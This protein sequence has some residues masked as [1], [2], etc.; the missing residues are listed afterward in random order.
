[1]CVPN[2]ESVLKYVWLQLVTAALLALTTLTALAMVYAPVK[3]VLLVKNVTCAQV[4]I[5]AINVVNVQADIKKNKVENAQVS[6]QIHLY[7]LFW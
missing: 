5:L 4:V 3:V 6:T 1:M 7:V 2:C